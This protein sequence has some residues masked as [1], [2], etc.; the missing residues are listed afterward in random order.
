MRRLPRNAIAARAAPCARASACWLAC[1]QATASPRC[2]S[3][4]ASPTRRLPLKQPAEEH[5]VVGTGE[6]VLLRRP[7]VEPHVR[8]AKR[9][10][11]RA[12]EVV[13]SGRGPRIGGVDRAEQIAQPYLVLHGDCEIE[14]P[15][16]RE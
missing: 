16:L 3:T 14:C 4:T 1:S 9:L 13:V 10:G 5:Q 6:T 11:R 2:C 12:G 15:R 7:A 8:W